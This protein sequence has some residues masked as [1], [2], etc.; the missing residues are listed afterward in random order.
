MKDTFVYRQDDGE[1]TARFT[2]IEERMVL[3]HK[4]SRRYR[5][6]FN[7]LVLVGGL[8]LAAIFFLVLRASA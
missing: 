5:H 1:I 8:Y 3:S 6:V 2:S 7:L 4:G